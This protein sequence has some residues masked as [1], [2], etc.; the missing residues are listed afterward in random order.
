MGRNCHPS[1]WRFLVIGCGSI[2]K[3]HIENLGRLG[4]RDIIA[5]DPRADRADEAAA[6]YG[7]KPFAALP[8]AWE[9]RPDVCLITA[10]TALHLALAAATHN[11]FVIRV[12]GAEPTAAVTAFRVLRELER[13][14]VP[15]AFG[16]QRFGARLNNHVV[17][18]AM[19]RGDWRGAV[20]AMMSFGA[21]GD[22]SVRSAASRY[23]AGD[24]RG[25]IAELPS[26]ASIE[27][28]VL[29][30]LEK[31]GSH[32][33]A[34]RSLHE[35]D[36]AFYISAA[37]SAAFNAYLYFRVGY[38]I[39]KRVVRVLYRLRLGF[40]DTLVLSGLPEPLAL[41]EARLLGAG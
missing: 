4:V 37:Q 11:R 38:W 14:G 5:F 30:S 27:R 8:A 28:L 12:R 19:L 7:V 16:Q 20:D 39:A 18:A 10:P 23:E 26:G 3:R 1:Q 9:R 33:R 31:G 2:G 25:A 17:G 6:A 21:G 15:N 24:P 22:D 32:E 35:R 13:H 41:A 40:G 34:I 36:I 29:R